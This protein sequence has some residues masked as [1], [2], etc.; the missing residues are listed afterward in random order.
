MFGLFKKPITASQFGEGIAQYTHEF[1]SGDSARALGMSFEDFDG[2]RGWA[3]FLEKKGIG[4]PFQKLHYRLWTHC[5][6]QAVCTQFEQQIGRV[7]TRGAM[8]AFSEKI[9]GY[10]F[11]STYDTLEGRYTGKQTFDPKIEALDAPDATLNFLSNPRV[12]VFNARYLF[13]AF[14]IPNMPN[15][16]TLVDGFRSYALTVCSSTSTAYRAVQQLSSSFK[17]S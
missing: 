2:S 4:L 5:A 17:L 3:P 12:G 15:Q 10:D 11:D 9:A 1:L 13:Q 8:E 7:I 16:Q 6:V 14:V